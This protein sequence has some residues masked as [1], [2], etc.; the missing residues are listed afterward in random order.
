[1]EE[2]GAAPWLHKLKPGTC[3]WEWV[4]EVTLDSYDGMPKEVAVSMGC[5]EV[6]PAQLHTQG[7]EPKPRPELVALTAV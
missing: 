2:Q 5:S 4:E 1:M 7:G 6:L 3:P